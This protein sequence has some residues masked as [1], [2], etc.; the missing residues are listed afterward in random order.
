MSYD[1]TTG[2]WTTV[3]PLGF[4]CADVNLYRYVSNAPIHF[5]D[6]MGLDEAPPPNTPPTPQQQQVMTGAIQYVAE[7]GASS[8]ADRV[9]LNAQRVQQ[10]IKDGRIRIAQ[11]KD[12]GTA[13]AIYH[14]QADIIVINAKH[15]TDQYYKDHHTT[16]D[17][18][19][20]DSKLD[21]LVMM[22]M[23]MAVVLMHET[24]HEQ[25]EKS[26][27]LGKTNMES[28]LE[29]MS[30]TLVAYRTLNRNYGFQDDNFKKYSEMIA[31]DSKKY[32][33]LLQKQVHG[34]VLPN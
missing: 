24:M 20:E 22:Q 17:G 33:E 10:L 27:R 30:I 23:F 3:D 31:E 7:V 9:K 16:F 5:I 29:A 2:R 6:P 26:S 4:A 14:K 11:E 12:M 13:I 19:K 8:N 18:R 1:P 25:Y 21:T 15:F 34:K 32:W 28:E